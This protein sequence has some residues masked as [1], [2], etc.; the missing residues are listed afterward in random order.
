VYDERYAHDVAELEFAAGCVRDE[1]KKRGGGGGGGTAGGDADD[2]SDAAA[3]IIEAALAPR[4]FPE[5][6]LAHCA[7]RYGVKSLAEKAAWELMCNAEAARSAG[8]HTSVDLFCAFCNRGYDDEELMFFLYVRQVRGAR[9]PTRTRHFRVTSHLDRA[10]V[11][12]DFKSFRIR[13]R[14]DQSNRSL[15]ANRIHRQQLLSACARALP[16]VDVHDVKGAS[17][18]FLA[19]PPAPPLPPAIALTEKRARDVTRSVFGGAVA[20]GMLCQAVLQ[21][22]GDFFKEKR[23]EASREK[24]GKGKGKG[25]GGGS[26][27]GGVDAAAEAT[28]EAY[29]YL[30]LMLSAYRDTRP[31]GGGE[32]DPSAAPAVAAREEALDRLFIGEDVDAAPSVTTADGGDDVSTSPGRASGGGWGAGGATSAATAAAATAADAAFRAASPARETNSPSG[33]LSVDPNGTYVK[34]VRRAIS[35]SCGMYCDVYLIQVARDV[36]PAT[37]A[38]IKAKATA[39][40]DRRAQGLF[41]GALA[42]AFPGVVVVESVDDV[43]GGDGAAAHVAASEPALVETTRRSVSALMRRGANATGAGGKDAKDVAKQILATKTI[44]ATVEP[45]L[46]RLL[47]ELPEDEFDEEEEEEEEENLD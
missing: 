39:E 5:Y 46:S 10:I 47:S 31:D 9:R 4:P 16:R 40:L 43:N 11:H 41:S 13:S 37:F 21:L 29:Y 25:K 15:T 33:K 45:M 20:D 32:D 24:K 18:R 28:M 38:E 19:G 22:V 44:R 8:A 2:E 1:K 35:N 42:A 6:V 3:A 36:A 17:Q 34:L 27:R 26:G 23:E 30:K 14:A 12:V 7:R